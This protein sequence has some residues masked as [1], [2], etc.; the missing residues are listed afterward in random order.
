MLMDHSK[1]EIGEGAITGD[2]YDWKRAGAWTSREATHLLWRTQSGASAAEIAR[3]VGTGLDESLDRL[4]QPQEESAEF[5]ST[6]RL[7]K[8]VALDSGNIES[9]KAWWF[10][11]MLHSANPLVER[12]TLF[13]H[14]HFATSN[15]KVRSTDHMAAQNELIR[16]EALGSFRKLLGAMT[17][18]VAMLKW[19]DGNANRKRSAN[20]NFAR[21]V[22]ELFSLGEGHYTERDIKEAARAFTGWHVRN[23]KFWINR[24]QHDQGNKTVFGKTG[25]LDGDDVVE[26][27]LAQKAS[28]LFLARK[29]LNA[30]VISE[31]TEHEVAGL[32][33]RIRTHDFALRPV[34]RELFS[35]DLFFSKRARHSLIKSPIALI[36]SASRALDNQA[37]L[38][39]AVRIAADL[40]QNLFEP[41]TVKGWEGGRL[42]INSASLLQRANF[43]A[44]LVGGSRY[45]R[46]TPPTAP[47]ETAVGIYAELLLARDLPD[48]TSASLTSYLQQSQGSRE[49]KLRGLIQLM[50]TMPESQLF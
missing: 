8:Q 43:A 22:M 39:N 11:R 14:N 16:S 5:T 10:Y 15:V 4:L 47:V 19:L 28:P 20:E 12:M 2:A 33:A 9:L 37:N 23:E 6:E 31:P 7:L 24:I 44:E 46:I 40:G 32:A 35:S 48:E 26:L 42:W 38:N 18:D 25:D 34:M 41:P 13:W 17:R 36:V 21:E 27:C 3:A 1:Q 50:L 30:F 49:E 29:L 45:G